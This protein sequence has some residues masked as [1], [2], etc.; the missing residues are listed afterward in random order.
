[1]NE[2]E[3]WINLRDLNRP[4]KQ[5][6]R[7]VVYDTEVSKIVGKNVATTDP[8]LLKLVVSWKRKYGTPEGYDNFLKI[9]ERLDELRETFK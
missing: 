9:P 4:K 6:E 8:R 3:E 5:P 2:N 1:M 7:K